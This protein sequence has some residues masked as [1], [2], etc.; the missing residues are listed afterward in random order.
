MQSADGPPPP[1][2]L[3]ADQRARLLRLLTAELDAA[4][5]AALTAGADLADLG[6]VVGDRISAVES[7]PAADEDEE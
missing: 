1:W 2:C 7:M 5:A 6:A 3:P 4:C